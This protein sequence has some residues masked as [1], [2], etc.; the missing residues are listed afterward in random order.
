MLSI[1]QTSEHHTSNSTNVDIGAVLSVFKQ[2]K[3]NSGVG[4]GLF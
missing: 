1:I 2:W 4:Y 3:E